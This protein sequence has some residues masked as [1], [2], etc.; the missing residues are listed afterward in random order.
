MAKIA[1]VQNIAYEYL[2]VMY[3]SSMLKAG[4]HSVDVFIARGA[5]SGSLFDEVAAY[6]PDIIGFSCTTGAHLWAVKTAAALK[7]RL[8]RAVIVLGGA[9]PTFFPDVIG[10]PGVDVVCRGEGEYALRELADRLDR[11]EG[12]HDIAN[13]WVKRGAE[14]VRND[15]RPLVEDL[16]S[17]PFPDRRLYPEKYRFLN[18]SQK[19][20]IV[21]RGCPFACSYCFN[22][23]LQQ[24]YK[25]KGRYVRLRSAGNVLAEIGAVRAAGDFKVVYI[26]DDTFSLDERWASE[27]LERYRREVGLPFICLVRADLLTEALVGRLKAAGCRN[28]FFGIESGSPEL[29]ALVLKKEMTDAE[30]IA[31]AALLKKYKIR[32]RTY[33]MFGLPGETLEDAFKTV[34]LNARIGTDYPWSALFQPFPGTELRE[35]ARQKGLL[36]TEAMEFDASFFKNSHLKLK[37]KKEIENL[38][39]LFFFAVKFPVLLPVIRMMVRVRLGPVYDA[40]FL[41]GYMYSFRKSESITFRETMAIGM[42]NIRNFFFAKQG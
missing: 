26:Q 14:V 24:L 42:N 38:Q 33:N 13:L 18:K 10:E 39:K 23:S 7:T 21:G 37:D 20:F 36:E 30:I 25:G 8:P 34:A 19:A 3:L 11:G 15:L 27:F 9:H 29:R 1:F 4:G 17:L 6:K 41:M 2:G 40:L 16:D 32:F 35:Y 31:G 22:H 28:V 12:Y 5:G